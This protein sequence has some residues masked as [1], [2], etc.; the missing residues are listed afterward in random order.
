MPNKHMTGTCNDCGGPCCSTADRCRPCAIESSR[1]KD[2][3]EHEIYNVLCP[4]IRE[5]WDEARYRKARGETQQKFV[6]IFEWDT[7]DGHKRRSNNLN[8]GT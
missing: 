1:P 7:H 6:E 5:G 2:P 4:K 3:T 8:P